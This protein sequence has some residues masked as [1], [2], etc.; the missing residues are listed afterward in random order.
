MA[1][2]LVIDDEEEIRILLTQILEKA[3][4]RVLCARDGAEGMALCRQQKIHLV[5]TD[6]IMPGQEGVETIIELRTD[7]PDIPVV[8]ISGGGRISGTRDFLNT[9]KVLGATR[10]FSKPFDNAELLYA[11]REL[12]GS[13]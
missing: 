12:V 2:I 11:V 6:L 8:A 9:A 7:Y 1:C 13:A 5:I 4:H 3:G 10:T